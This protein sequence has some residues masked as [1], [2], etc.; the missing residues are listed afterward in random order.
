MRIDIELNSMFGIVINLDTFSLASVDSSTYGNDETLLDKLY[1]W[2]LLRIQILL[3]KFSLSLNQFYHIFLPIKSMSLVLLC[4]LPLL[5]IA[6][7][8]FIA[9]IGLISDHPALAIGNWLLNLC[10]FGDRIG[11]IGNCE[12]LNLTLATDWTIYQ[13]LVE[14]ATIN[15]VYDFFNAR[16]FHFE[17]FPIIKGIKLYWRLG[18]VS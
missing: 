12:L 3:D 4:P 15:V 8:P 10:S 11:A 18:P 1:H 2:P 5:M 17:I 14:F 16:D 9:F 7:P 6:L 13:K